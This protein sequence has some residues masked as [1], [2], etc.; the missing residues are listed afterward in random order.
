MIPD[1]TDTTPVCD[2]T[3]PEEI[4][5]ACRATAF[6][7]SFRWCSAVKES[8][9]AFEV[10]DKLGV[11]LFHIEPKLVGV[12]DTFWVVVGDL[13][14]AY[15]V[16]ENAK[17]WYQA[18]QRYIEEM[19]LAYSAKKTT[20]LISKARSSSLIFGQPGALIAWLGRPI[21]W[22][23]I[24]SSTTR[25]SQSSESLWIQTGTRSSSSPRSTI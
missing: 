12:D 9:Q 20:W 8:Y 18:L 14:P 25:D 16:C 11:F 3:D 23:P 4:A 13:P 21:S 5:L 17:D 2:L 22:K 10:A 15:L 19:Q 24:R 1:I 6:L 7:T